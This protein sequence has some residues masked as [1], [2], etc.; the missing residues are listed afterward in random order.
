MPAAVDRGR[1]LRLTEVG[2]GFA[3]R[4]GCCLDVAEFTVGKGEQAA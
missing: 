2:D 1:G 4:L 3:G